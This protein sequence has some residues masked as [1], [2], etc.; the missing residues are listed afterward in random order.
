VPDLGTTI[1]KGTST[2]IAVLNQTASANDSAYDI[3]SAVLTSSS[4][5]FA[6]RLNVA[7]TING[8]NVL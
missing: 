6:G 3:Y 7:A 8:K 5:I 2:Y 1:P 4:S